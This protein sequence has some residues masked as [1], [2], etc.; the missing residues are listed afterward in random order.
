M[1]AIPLRENSLKSSINSLYNQV[2]IIHLALNGFSK[3]PNF[4]LNL[5]KV[6]PIILNNG[7]GDANK[8][9]Y[10]E[11]YNKDEH[12]YFSCDDDIIYPPNYISTYITNI[13]KYSCL[14]TSHGSTLPSNKISSYFKDRNL[15]SHYRKLNESDVQI[16]IPGTGVSG[17]N[18][19]HLKL[20]FNFFLNENMADIFVGI[21]CKL[22]NVKCMSISH[23]ENWIKDAE[24]DEND[25]LYKKHKL[26]DSIQTEH[27]NKIKWK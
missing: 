8:Y 9:F 21:A 23:P 17:F 13:N 25:T 20:K 19:S 3:I 26:N 2:D 10:I 1:A 11:Q 22:Q 5:P 24:Y 6:K 4:L 18:T 12:Y 16:D 7:L 27:L 14:I 15:L